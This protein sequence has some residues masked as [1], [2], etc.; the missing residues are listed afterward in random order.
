MFAVRREIRVRPILKVISHIGLVFTPDN[1]FHGRKQFYRFLAKGKVK[2][3]TLQE[4]IYIGVPLVFGIRL[5][6]QILTEVVPDRTRFPVV[7]IFRT[8]VVIVREYQIQQT[9]F[10]RRIKINR[11]VISCKSQLGRFLERYSKRLVILR[12]HGHI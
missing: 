3:A 11:N 10:R 12:V 6:K 1:V 8:L 5:R 9:G 4:E 7:V 2:T